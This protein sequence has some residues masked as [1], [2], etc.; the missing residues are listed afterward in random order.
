M[1]YL[2]LTKSQGICKRF[3]YKPNRIESAKNLNTGTKIW[4]R[5]SRTGQR[6]RFLYFLRKNGRVGSY[7]ETGSNT[8][9]FFFPKVVNIAT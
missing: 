1:R 4:D 5:S 3:D 8:P 7:T 2:G 9:N 6:S